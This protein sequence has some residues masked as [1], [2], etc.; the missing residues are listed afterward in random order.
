[1]YIVTEQNEKGDHLLTV[2][3]FFCPN[4]QKPMPSSETL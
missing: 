1:M 2:V 4:T 3:D